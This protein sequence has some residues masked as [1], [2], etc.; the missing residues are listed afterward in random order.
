MSWRMA[1]R[2]VTGYR[3]TK[4]VAASYNEARLT[5][6]STNNQLTIDARLDV[7]PPTRLFRYWDYWGTMVHAFDL[8]VPHRELVV[9]ATSVVETPVA[10]ASVDPAACGWE[11][12]ES[13]RTHERQY[14]YLVPSRF[15]PLTAEVAA[16]AAELRRDASTPADGVAHAV[17]WVNSRLTYDRG[18]TTVST[19]A[20]E[21][22]RAG[23]GVCQDFVHLTL[24]VLRSMGIPARYAS[25]YFHPEPD[26]ALDQTVVA[27]SHAWA[28]AWLGDWYPVDPTNGVPVGQRHVL[29]GRGRDYADVTPLKGVY[30]G[31]PAATPT[32]TVE[33]TR[34]A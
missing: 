34:Q 22:W 23:R 15:V 27:E 5:P 6:L 33:I 11:A 1:V 26:A 10:H 8:H 18:S 31:A 30:S 16:V 28:E 2:H 29:I 12:V 14:E 21:A 19:S 32:V 17:T 7:E 24:A 9:T 20:L 4:D 3:Y 25:G 13:P